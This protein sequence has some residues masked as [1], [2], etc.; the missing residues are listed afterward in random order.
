MNFFKK[1]YTLRRFYAPKYVKGY[2]TI[3]Y[4][5][6][7]VLMDVQTLSD[8][9]ITTPDGSRAVERLKVF[10][11]T[12]ILVEDTE[13]EQKADRIYFQEKWFDC[14]SS[15]LSD[16]TILRHYTATFVEVLDNE[17]GPDKGVDM[18]HEPKSD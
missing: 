5:D 6:R 15:R 4:S 3:P 13:K 9:I 11:D 2:S 18:E 7:T 17:P 16:N 10:C 1:P 8:D 12:E 14:R